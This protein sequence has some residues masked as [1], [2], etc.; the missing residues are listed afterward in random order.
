MTTKIDRFCTHPLTE[1]EKEDLVNKHKNI[2]YYYANRYRFLD[3]DKEEIQGWGFVGLAQAINEY[4][5]KRDLEF[6]TIA[7]FRVRQE[8]FN[9]YRRR[10][11]QAVSL[12]STVSNDVDKTVEEYLMDES[13]GIL[14][15]EEYIR[16]LI[17][18]ALA[19]EQRLHKI[20][21][22]DW[23]LTLKTSEEIAKEN[24]ITLSS[25]RKIQRQG[26]ALIKR[27]LINNDV[28]SEYLGNGQ[29]KI[30]KR[31]IIKHEGFTRDDYRKIKYIRREFPY[32]SRY[33]IALILKTSHQKVS[34]LLKS[35][36]LS[37]IGCS[38]DDTIKENV[39]QYSKRKYP[40]QTPG[41]VV[42]YNK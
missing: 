1:D 33:D 42:I 24:R 10:P 16:H 32:L 29:S 36:T 9:N 20:I 18:E 14:F 12:Q 4:E 17:K 7:F 11:Q 39:M 23:L 27:Y 25:V 6:S 22:I 38:A 40:A 30:E 5:E 35:P 37:Y 2:V 13:G 26:Q 19:K 41:E 21:N 3:L 34:E 15:D 31:A 8:I 28:I